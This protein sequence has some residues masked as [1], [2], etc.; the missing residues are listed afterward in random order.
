MTDLLRKL[1]P[2]RLTGQIVALLIL[3]L[4]LSQ[5][6]SFWIFGYEWRKVLGDH[7]R[8]FMLERIASVASLL[9]VAPAEYHSQILQTASTRYIQFWISQGPEFIQTDTPE[10]RDIS[11]RLDALFAESNPRNYYVASFEQNSDSKFRTVIGMQL[12]D[13]QWLN[14]GRV[15]FLRFAPP[16]QHRAILLMTFLLIVFGIVI[17]LMVRRLTRPLAEL[18][19][20]AEKAGRG[21]FL[22]SLPEQGTP[23]VRLLI[24]SFNRMQE[25]LQRFIR[26]RMQML[27]AMNHDLRTPITSLKL[28]IEML[29]DERSKQKLLQTT[30]EMQHMVEATLEYA[31]QDSVRE[32]TQRTDLDALVESICRDFSDMGHAVTFHGMGDIIYPCRPSSLK[33]A[34]RNLVDNAVKYGEEVSVDVSETADSYLITIND[35]GPGIA[36]GD[37]ERVFEP[38]V[39]LED[40]RSRDTG[41]VG[42]GLAIARTCIHAHGG[43]IALRDRDAGGLSVLVNLPKIMVPELKA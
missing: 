13:S 25:R 32:E 39:R 1:I 8:S 23:D 11:E 20:A 3:V 4:L 14:Y 31:R 24:N 17:V 35:R 40:S 43:T 26:G 33:R 42:L 18:T 19:V 10:N 12:A 30:D 36:V 37:R 6:L 5:V 2:Q 27:A 15:P 21:E 34:L 28:Q 16:P 7:E 29:D 38:F 22:P 9:D 41:G